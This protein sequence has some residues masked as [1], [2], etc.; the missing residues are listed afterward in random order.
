MQGFQNRTF[1]Q[2]QKSH[3]PATQTLL[4]SCPACMG[5]QHQVLHS[6]HLPLNR[7]NLK[8]RPLCFSDCLFVC[9]CVCWGNGG[10][11]DCGQDGTHMPSGS[12]PQEVSDTSMASLSAACVKVRPRSRTLPRPQRRGRDSTGHQ[13]APMLPK[14]RRGLLHVGDA[15]LRP[16]ALGYGRGGRPAAL[17]GVGV[18]HIL[19]P[20][21]GLP[22]QHQIFLRFRP[23]PGKAG[24]F[25]AAGTRVAPAP[26]P[27]VPGVRGAVATCLVALA[28]QR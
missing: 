6:H 3:P 7:L 1:R 15:P 27:E 12:M 26:A 18:V 10:C 2:A 23:R 17:D 20:Q 21:A 24:G 14:S 11:S 5:S 16:Q 25:N 19:A 22:P 8:A 9:V 4:A 28:C 13:P